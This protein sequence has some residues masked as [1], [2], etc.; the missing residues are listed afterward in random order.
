MYRTINLNI[1]LYLLIDYM[2]DEQSLYVHLIDIAMNIIF[3]I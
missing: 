1:I 3:N 2:L